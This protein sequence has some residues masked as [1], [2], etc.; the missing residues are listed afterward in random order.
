MALEH[1]IHQHAS[2]LEAEQTQVTLVGTPVRHL[3]YKEA[4]IATKISKQDAIKNTNR[5]AMHYQN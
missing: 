5:G 2:S 3:K 4:L 1:V